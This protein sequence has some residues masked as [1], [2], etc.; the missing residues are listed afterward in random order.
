MRKSSRPG[1]AGERGFGPPEMKEVAD[2]GRP[3]FT[4]GRSGVLGIQGAPST[5]TGPELQP[6]PLRLARKL[7]VNRD[8]SGVTMFP[9]S[10][11]FLPHWAVASQQ[12]DGHFIEPL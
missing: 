8:L 2:Q 6:K 3:L 4:D 10:G 11:R 5:V 7:H 9:G 12:C 1:G